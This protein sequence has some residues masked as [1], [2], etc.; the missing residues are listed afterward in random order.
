MKYSVKIS[1][2]RPL[3]LTKSADDDHNFN[4]IWQFGIDCNDAKTLGE[5]D[6]IQVLEIKGENIYTYKDT[7]GVYYLRLRESIY[8]TTDYL[9]IISTIHDYILNHFI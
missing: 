7:E 2:F 6:S 8:H 5:V 4:L 1:T 3:D 9:N